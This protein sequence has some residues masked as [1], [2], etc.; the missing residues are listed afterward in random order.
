MIDAGTHPRME[1]SSDP[2]TMEY[3]VEHDD[4]D[5]FCVESVRSLI[6][7]KSMVSIDG[8]GA[9][10]LSREDVLCEKA[11]DAAGGAAGWDATLC[12]CMPEST[13]SAAATGRS[14]CITEPI[15]PRL[16]SRGLVLIV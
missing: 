6:S 13:S 5:L 12:I 14:V 8:A 2:A 7:G 4:S 10:A 11:D 1:N 3:T 15:L 9:G 16:S